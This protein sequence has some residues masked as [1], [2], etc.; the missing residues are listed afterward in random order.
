MIVVKDFQWQTEPSQEA[1]PSPR[2]RDSGWFVFLILLG[3][4]GYLYLNLFQL[5]NLP[6]LLS[7]DQTF[8]G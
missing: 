3:I 6:I 2:Y 8:S 4:S 7:G 1:R 5:P